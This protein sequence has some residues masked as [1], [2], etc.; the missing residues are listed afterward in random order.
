MPS[1]NGEFTRHVTL[2]SNLEAYHQL[3]D[4]IIDELERRGW[5]PEHLFAIRMALEESIS[6]AVR[7]GNKHD[8]NKQVFVDCRCSD[9]SFWVQVRD[10]GPGFCPE[11]VPDC[12][13]DDR[14][15]IPGGRGLALM[16]AFMTRM[17]YNDRG[18]VLTM[19]KVLPK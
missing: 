6:N 12:C 5:V 2:P 16:R 1:R 4:E 3:I 13:A 8:P 11:Q 10:E 9:R 19:E 14:L 7:H 18:N 15:E 17:E